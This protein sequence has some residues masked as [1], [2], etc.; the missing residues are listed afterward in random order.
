MLISILVGVAVVIAGFII[1][2]AS[3]SSEFRVARSA[4]IPASTA[5]V[6]EQVNDFHN[7]NAW[8]PWARID[9]DAKNSYEGADAGEGAKFHWEGNKVGAGSMTLVESRPHELIR[10]RLEFLRPFKATNAVEFTFQPS[11]EGTL[12]T[13]TMTGRNSFPAKAM[14]L[15]IDC[16]KMCGGQFEQGLANLSSV[17]AE[18]VHR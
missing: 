4:T 11:G 2:V 16:E 9:P 5:V 3:R 14:G 8:S 12:V 13:W 7:W 1:V 6:F 17:V 18:P 10:I 15:F